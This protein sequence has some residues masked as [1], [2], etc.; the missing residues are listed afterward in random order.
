[1]FHLSPKADEAVVNGAK[2]SHEASKEVKV[3]E[4]KPK[5]KE[6]LRPEG[7]SMKTESK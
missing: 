5:N 2:P 4:N 1:M 7:A 3:V 6:T